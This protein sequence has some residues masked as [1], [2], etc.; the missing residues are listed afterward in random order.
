MKL[1]SLLLSSAL[2]AGVGGI[3]FAATVHGKST[4]GDPAQAAATDSAS[5]LPLPAGSAL[6]QQ[7]WDNASRLV[8]ETPGMTPQ[9]RSGLISG[10]LLDAGNRG[11]EVVT[12]APWARTPVSPQYQNC[13]LVVVT[14]PRR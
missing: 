5:P 8:C 6:P 1:R 7:L 4:P 14:R 12:V 2:A 10:V 11:Y 3:G 13:V 9:E